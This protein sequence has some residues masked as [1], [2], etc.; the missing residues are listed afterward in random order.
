MLA[1]KLG[2]AFNR[3]RVRSGFL[4]LVRTEA[5]TSAPALAMLTN[6][7]SRRLDLLVK[8]MRLHQQHKL[9]HGDVA[10]RNVVITPTAEHASGTGTARWIDLG[11]AHTHPRCGGRRCDE[12]RRALADMGL[13]EPATRDELS[14][15]VATAGLRW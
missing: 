1:R 12:L 3:P 2:G 15:R 7:L 14:R 5:S 13:G 10:P 9:A 4:P 11:L 8:L 6:N